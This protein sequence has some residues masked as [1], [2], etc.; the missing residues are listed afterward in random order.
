MLGLMAEREELAVVSDQHG[1][2]TWT[3]DLARA[4]AALVGA[5]PGPG[6]LYH[7][8]AAGATSWYDFAC[9]IQRL[10][11]ELGLLSRRCAIR[12]IRSADYPARARRPA[13]SVLS[14]EKLARDYGLALRG[15]GE[16][17]EE[18]LASLAMDRRGTD[19]PGSGS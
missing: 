6:G 5:P 18:Y 10:G 13:W 8:S 12:P 2:P 19:A 16:G 3:R 7:C 9:R 17:L 14:S 15:W 11:L 1:S 4:I